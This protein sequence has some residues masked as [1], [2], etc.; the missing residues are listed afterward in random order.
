MVKYGQY[1]K[2]YGNIL[3][4]GYGAMFWGIAHQLLGRS[5]DQKAGSIEMGWEMFAYL[6]YTNKMNGNGPDRYFNPKF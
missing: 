5:Y 3:T 1:T 6:W 4:A 2:G